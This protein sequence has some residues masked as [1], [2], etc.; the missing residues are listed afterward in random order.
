MP[1]S[2]HEDFTLAPPR[3]G[4]DRSFGLVFAG[5]FT[6]VG[7]APLMNGAAIRLWS[8]ALALVLAAAAL[9][10]PRSL[11][12]VNRLWFRFGNLLSR[13]TLPLM[14]GFLFFGILTPIALLRRRFS[15]PGLALRYARTEPSY[16]I[17]RQDPPGRDSF[18]R[19]F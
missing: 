13:V 9:L 4:S 19:Q 7:L 1:S 14:M 6:L 8:L 2:F 3:Q 17:P 16:W 15:A 10:L 5:I 18:K 11:S 12:Q